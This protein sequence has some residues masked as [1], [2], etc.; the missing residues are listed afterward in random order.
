MGSNRSTPGRVLDCDVLVIGSGAGGLSAAITAAHHGLDVVVVEKDSGLGGATAWSGGWMWTPRHPLARAEGFVED[1]DRPRTYLKSVLGEHFD[2]RRIDA[3]LENAP[4]MVGFFHEKTSMRF[5]NGMKIADIHGD[6]PGA[7]A[8][9]RQVGPQPLNARRLPKR[10]RGKLLRQMYETSFLGMGIMAGPDLQH[11]LH[12]TRSVRSFAHA[13]RRVSTH[14]F[15]LAVYRRGMS[16]VNGTALVAR[17]AKSAD[18]LG[19]RMYVDSPARSLIEEDGA[20]RGAVVATPR[21]EVTV[22]ARRGTVLATGGFSGDAE[23][24]R[25]HFPKTTGVDHHTL[26]PAGNTG[27]GIRMAEAVG[28]VLDTSG[29]SPAAWCPVSLMRLPNGRTATFP[30]I[31]DRGK[32]GVIGVLRTGERF[33]NEGDGYYQYVSAMIDA[34]PEGE[35][36]ASWLV[37]DHRFQRLYPF[38]MSKPFPVPQFPYLANGYL[39]HGRSL[40]ELARDC[41]IDPVG[42]RR[43]V[44]EFNAHARAGEDPVF[45]R[46]ATDFNRSSGDWMNEPNPSLA[47]IE[48]G[49]FYAVKVHPGSFGTFAGLRTDEHARVVGADGAP[50]GGLYAAGTDQSN[51]MGGHYP[52]GGINIGPA[53]TFGYVAGRHLAG[54]KDH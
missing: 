40:E 34:T 27:D 13:A 20:V 42:L 53:M 52:S 12:A 14:L 16:F 30:H 28:G 51:V 44:E 29:A 21:G 39:R 11:F 48:Q 33:V 54:A 47:P 37:C 15:D 32:P 45:G 2:G 6:H 3:F 43:T 10:L 31:I 38:G 24:V 9:G 18:D 19:V 49:P 35:E 36:V 41:G 25:E 5:V 50:V 4:H 26:A 7:S 17:L 23:R 22:R 8:Q 1:I 46:G